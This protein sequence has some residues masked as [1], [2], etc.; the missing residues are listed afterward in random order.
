MIKVEKVN[1]KFYDKKNGDFY[2]LDDINFNVEQG[3]IFGLLGPNGAGKTTMLRI[4]ATIMG[5]TEG[6]VTVNGY[7]TVKNPEEVKK[8]IGFL[9]G[10]T[11][12]YKKLTPVETEGTEKV[13][14]KRKKA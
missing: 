4:M 11:K 2:A 14:S 1:K 12:L 7:D 6:T 3:E 10:N 5:Q 9:S 13:P 8:S